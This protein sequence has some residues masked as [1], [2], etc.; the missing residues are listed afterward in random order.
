[1]F[2]K[3]RLSPAPPFSDN[4]SERK[5]MRASENELFRLKWGYKCMQLSLRVWTLRNRCT[6][7][8][9]FLEP[10]RKRKFGSREIGKFEISGVKLQWSKSKFKGNDFGSSYRDFW[11]IEGSPKSGYISFLSIQLALS[12][13]TCKDWSWINFELYFKLKRGRSSSGKQDMEV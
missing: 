4:A 13:R 7:E 1:M 9:R 6:V 8:S 10:P 2:L 3:F 12:K 11:E 5:L